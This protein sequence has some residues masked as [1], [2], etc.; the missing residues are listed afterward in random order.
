MNGNR[1]DISQE[2]FLWRVALD[3]FGHAGLYQLVIELWRGAGPPA[4]PTVEYLDEH[5]VGP[6][7]INLLKIAQEVGGVVP[8]TE[9]SS[10][11][12]RLYSRHAQHLVDG[13]LE[14]MPA[15]MLTRQ[16]RMARV[17]NDMGV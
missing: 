6:V 16:M 9:Y 17:S 10:N 4:R 12:V 2:A 14:R 15:T 3:Y 13:L 8:F 7:V 11:R 5:E 1:I